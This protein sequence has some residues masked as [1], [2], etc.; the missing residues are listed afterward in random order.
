MK[1]YWKKAGPCK[2]WQAATAAN[3]SLS[4]KILLK[5]K[6]IDVFTCHWMHSIDSVK[7]RERIYVW[8]TIMPYS[9]VPTEIIGLF[10]LSNVTPASYHLRSPKG[11]NA[12]NSKI[13]LTK[14]HKNCLTTRNCQLQDLFFFS[15][16]LQSSW[17]FEYNFI[18]A[19]RQNF[20]SNSKAKL[21]FFFWFFFLLLNNVVCWVI[22]VCV[23]VCVGPFP[24][25][26][27]GSD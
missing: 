15:F 26:S 14:P 25:I 8:T 2:R 13:G 7:E 12:I 17:P 21:T 6:E 19:R 4:L 5:R 1:W 11:P 20:K 24:C 22:C 16:L 10:K 18:S 27:F 9:A 3:S 23:C